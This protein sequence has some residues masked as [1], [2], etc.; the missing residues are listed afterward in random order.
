MGF[1]DDARGL[2]RSTASG[3]T[4]RAQRSGR[5]VAAAAALA[6]CQTRRKHDSAGST[7]LSLGG[8]EEYGVA[9]GRELLA[10][11]MHGR[12]TPA[13]GE[14]A[15]WERGLG[16][17][18]NR[19]GGGRC[20]AVGRRQGEAAGVAPMGSSPTAPGRRWEQR[21]WAPWLLGEA[22]ARSATVGVGNGEEALCW[23]FRAPWSKKQRKP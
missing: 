12:G 1:D 21:A 23:K 6:F 2:H 11:G 3:P 17:G 18:K 7:L 4:W 13:L 5:C 16:H 20:A 9:L 10:A 14:G 15:G 8:V 19:E 22:G